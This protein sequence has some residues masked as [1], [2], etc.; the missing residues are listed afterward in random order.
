MQ[1]RTAASAMI[2]SR[3]D[4][5]AFLTADMKSAGV[6]KWSLRGRINAPST[7]FVRRLRRFEYV[8]N[9]HGGWPAGWMIYLVTRLRFEAISRKYGYSIPA[10][11]FGPGLSIAHL[12]TI[13]INS[14]ARVGA[15][16]RLH[17]GVTIGSTRGKA[18]L[19]GD[20]VFMAP[21]S[22][23]YGEVVV[24]DRVHLGPGVVIIED[25]GDDTVHLPAAA[26]QRKRTRDTWWQ[27]T[28]MTAAREGEGDR[29]EQE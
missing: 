6:V 12:G 29:D 11:V 20:E 17:H 3:E 13:V 18:P 25:V 1:K 4:Y 19:I 26:S 16:C 27:S 23:V 15:N 5:D 22:S 10:N 28:Q 24:G 2:N 21:G 14:K 8:K 7:Y 9:C